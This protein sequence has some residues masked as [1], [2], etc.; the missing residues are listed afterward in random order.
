METRKT[1]DR[2]AFW[3]GYEDP[4]SEEMH[5]GRC[6]CPKVVYTGD[7]RRI[8]KDELAY[9]DY[10]GYNAGFNVGP[11]FGCIHWEPR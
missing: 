9:W 8:G 11:K 4:Y 6:S 7:G 1:C 3:Q 10:E 5:L 2:C